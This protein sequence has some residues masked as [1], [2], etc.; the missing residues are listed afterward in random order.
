MTGGPDEVGGGSEK[1]GW[2]PGATYGSCTE[3]FLVSFHCEMLINSLPPRKSKV[4]TNHTKYFP[5]IF[6]KWSC[7][8]TGRMYIGCY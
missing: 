6:S 2:E 1:Y 3:W 8:E 5:P 4:L 7:V